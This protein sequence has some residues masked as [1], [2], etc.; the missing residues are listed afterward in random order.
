MVVLTAEYNKHKNGLS[1]A[2]FL[3]SYV[4]VANLQSS[5]VVMDAARA[6]GL[7]DAHC[8]PTDIMPMTRK[9]GQMKAKALTIMAT[10]DQDQELV[11]QTAERYRISDKADLYHD[12]KKTYTIPSFG[13]H[14]WFSHLMYDDRDSDGEID[15]KAHYRAILTPT[16]D[17]DNFLSTLPVP[18]RLTECLRQLEE[19]LD[20][21]PLALVGEIGLDRSF[22]LPY[23]PFKSPEDPEAKPDMTAK[24]GGSYEGEYTPGSREGRPLTPYRV[25]LNHQ[26]MI[27]K[28]QLQVAAKHNRAVSVHS[29]ATHGAAFDV[30][31]E[32]WKGQERPSKSALKKQKK[33]AE[34]VPDEQD[35]FEQDQK[36][37]SYPPRI[38]MHSYSGPVDSLTQF[39][40]PRVPA[41]I[42]F[43]FSELVNFGSHNSSKAI[44]VVKTVPDD[45]I[46]IESDLHCAGKKMDELLEDIFKRVCEI[47]KWKYKHGAKQLKKNWERF[48]FGPEGDDEEEQQE[49][50]EENSK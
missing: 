4:F 10:R 32:L 16:P 34:H 21:F 12:S 41:D 45:K 8:H 1:A 3:L 19:K 37:K 26:K 33:D 14:P 46:L 31:S 20:R 49:N 42:F 36:S 17:D 2:L 22:R 18:R 39:L 47:R 27:L 28:A 24:A 13:W 35:E 23:G 15:A 38:C 9:I 29:V 40:G 44:E 43:S 5:S 25:S 6:V 48:V 7:F 11:R 50:D 30:F